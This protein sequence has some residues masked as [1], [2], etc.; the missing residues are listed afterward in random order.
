MSL[1][2]HHFRKEARCILGRWFF[3]LGLLTLELAVQLEW[4]MPMHGVENNV[5]LPWWLHAGV[6]MMAVMLTLVG[7]TEDRPSTEAAFIATR[8]LPRRSYFLGR[9]LLVVILFILPLALQ[10]TVYLLLSGRPWTAVLMDASWSAVIAGAWLLW[11]VPGSALWKT[12]WQALLGGT[13][14]LTGVWLCAALRTD[15]TA[16]SMPTQWADKFEETG[17]V[18]VAWLGL[19]AWTLLAWWH[20]RASWSLVKRLGA[21]AAFAPVFYAALVGWQWSVSQETAEDRTKVATLSR[22]VKM[23]IPREKLRP[24]LNASYQGRP[25]IALY[26]QVRPRELSPQIEMQLRLKK[27][28]ARV[29]DRLVP[30][31]RS[32]DDAQLERQPSLRL[33]ADGLISAVPAGTVI[34]PSRRTS[35]STGLDLWEHELGRVETADLGDSKEPLILTSHFES[36]WYEWTQMADLPMEVGAHTADEDAAL[37]ITQLLPDTAGWRMAKRG[38]EPGTMTFQCRV[39]QRGDDVDLRLVIFSPERRAAWGLG[40]LVING[41][42]YG[43]AER[44]MHTG[45]Q[46]R[47]IRLSERKVLRYEDGTP[48]ADVGKLRLIV[49]K[50]RC[51]GRSEWTWQSPAL[52]LRQHVP[53]ARDWYYP[54]ASWT[55]GDPVKRLQERLDTLAAPDA[56]AAPDVHRD[57]VLAVL[58]SFHTLR[59]EAHKQVQYDL[60]VEKLRPFAQ[61]HLNI[62]LDLPA[63]AVAGPMSPVFRLVNQLCDE[64][65]RD[66]VVSRILEADWMAALVSSKGWSDDAREKMLTEVMKV[67]RHEKHLRSMLLKWKEPA[68]Q[69][70]QVQEL[71]F[72]PDPE[73][74]KTL[75]AVPELRPQLHA[76]AKDLEADLRPVRSWGQAMRPRLE[77]AIAE[78]NKAAL[79]TALAW[80]NVIQPGDGLTDEN[81]LMPL[82]R[83][84]APQLGLSAASENAKAM[85]RQFRGLSA[86]QFEYSPESRTWS[87]KP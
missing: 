58:R 4:L 19:G 43:Q 48:A 30:A 78:G 32:H 57:Y 33:G 1:A 15:F 61:E 54:S 16:G 8:P 3:W 35:F 42:I 13:V 70:R 24:L 55:L 65:H 56:S 85:I 47:L 49:M 37:T 74:F 34:S 21:M 41:G 28:E 52:D 51:L 17:V 23:D 46:R 29:G 76:V 50:R 14:L 64:R 20:Q 71:R 6:M 80:I 12:W 73:T 18:F 31:H 53:G 83:D 62:L 40:E 5:I 22:E 66:K 25:A 2:F 72:F 11:T 84:L 77:I 44:A 36:T 75:Y 63:S 68:V 10:E 7:C 87:K 9:L 81:A 39:H 59:T 60:T 86:S 38:S 69:Q 45:W 27:V 82:A 79:E 67:P 26:G